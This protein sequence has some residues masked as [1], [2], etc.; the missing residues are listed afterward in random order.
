[1][2]RCV[3]TFNDRVRGFPF[4]NS[5]AT[6]VRTIRRTYRQ[7]TCNRNA[8]LYT[9]NKQ[10]TILACTV[11]V[12][13]SR[14]IYSILV[15]VLTLHCYRPSEQCDTGLVLHSFLVLLYQSHSQMYEY[16]D[17]R[18]LLCSRASIPIHDGR[19]LR[20]VKNRGGVDCQTCMQNCYD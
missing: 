14:P 7:A 16:M 10:L 8:A 3:W 2:F 6:T 11:I 1:M 13:S 4:P 15:S 9:V 12:L 20:P 19:S 18:E 17:L 5:V